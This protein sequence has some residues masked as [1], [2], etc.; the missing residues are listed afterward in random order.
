[1]GLTIESLELIGYD[2]ESDA[3]PST[4]FSNLSPRPLPYR[5][6]VRGTT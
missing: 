3:L 2:P 6:D 1:V 5:R 4:V